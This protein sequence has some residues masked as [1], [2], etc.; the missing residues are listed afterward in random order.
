M[1]TTKSHVYPVLL[2]IMECG[3]LYSMSLVTMLATYLTASNS[4]YIVIDMVHPPEMRDLVL[5]A[6]NTA[7]DR[8]NYSNHILHDHRSDG[9]AAVQR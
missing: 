8:P 9:D 2:V 4:A 6:D 5:H 7:S 1:R 3:A